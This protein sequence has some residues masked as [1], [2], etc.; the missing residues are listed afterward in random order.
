ME[1][2]RADEAVPEEDERTRKERLKDFA[3]DKT[4]KKLKNPTNFQVRFRTGFVY[5]VVSVVCVLASEWTTLA[6]L[7]AMAGITA[8]E[9]YYMLRQDAKLP[10]EMLGIIAAML[11][12]V[13]VFFLGLDGALYVSLALLLALI[14][15]YVFWMRA[16][17]PDVGVSFFGAAYCGMLLSGIIVVREALPAPWGGVL[18]LGILLSVWAN[19]SFAYLVGSKFGKHKLA[20]RTSPKKSWEGFFAGLAGSAVF[21][22]LMTLVPGVTMSVPQAI[23]FGLASGLMGV[24]G[25]LAESRIKR[26]SGFKDSGTIMPGHG[27]LL[28]RC[29]SLFLVAVTSAI[30]LVAGGCIPY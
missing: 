27:G 1:P 23:L 26:N 14:V 9:F 17:V 21:W 19:D 13:S 24:L 10:N 29:D 6:L 11:Y 20:P 2:R 8:G 4:P 18:V 28:D 3:Q 15:W 25:D 7:V 12:P 22:C 30:L 16:R 5:I